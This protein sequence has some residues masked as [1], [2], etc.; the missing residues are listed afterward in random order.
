MQLLDKQKYEIIVKY[1]LNQS[2]RMISKNMNINL[3]TVSKWINKYEK[4]KNINRQI[5]SGRKDK[6]TDEQKNIIIDE[7]KKND[8]IT[9]N[10]IQQNIEEKNIHISSSTIRNILHE[11]N[12]KYKLPKLK[13]LL[14]VEHKKKD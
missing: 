10:H 1:E 9:V 2:M 12:F 7:I 13:P 3:K 14:T 5:G 4:D 11:H 8:L 6:L